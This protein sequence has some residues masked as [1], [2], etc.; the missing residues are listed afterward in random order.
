MQD[1]S[2]QE[3]S[4]SGTGGQDEFDLP[5]AFRQQAFDIIAGAFGA[6][7]DARE[8]SRHRH[9][10]EHPT[11]RKVRESVRHERGLESLPDCHEFL[12]SAPARDVLMFTAEAFRW[13][14]GPYR[15]RQFN[16]RFTNCMAPDAA[17]EE[18]NKR[19]AQHGLPFRW[20]DGRLRRIDSDYLNAQVTEPAVRLLRTAGFEGAEAE[21][22]SARRSYLGDDHKAT[23]E[24]ATKAIESTLKAIFDA[25]ARS[26]GPKDGA[27]A[28]IDS[29]MNCGLVPDYLRE[30]F[31]GI[32][33]VLIGAPT[34]R[35]HE[36]GVGHG[37][38]ATI[39]AV[40]KHVTAYALHSAGAAILF[41]IESHRAALTKGTD[42]TG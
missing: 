26:Y 9:R 25:R 17:I 24:H 35:N 8:L 37:Q 18:L 40:P 30:H 14:D 34:I 27:S 15:D 13:I 23:I 29:A 4:I 32:S 10:V 41:F 6:S 39:A 1:T 19:F 11:W 12:K 21:F 5:P 2:V 20:A 42:R 3:H 22:L 7:L 16:V 36:R 33:K 31:T 28:L 38:G